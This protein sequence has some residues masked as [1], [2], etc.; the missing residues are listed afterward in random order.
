MVAVAHG[1][2][3][4]LRD[5]RLRV[6]QQQ[7]HYRAALVELFFHQLGFQPKPLAGT[8]HHRPARRGAAAHEQ[9]HP[10]QALTT[11]DGDF[12]RGTVF[13]HVEQRNDG[14]AWKVH[15]LHGA[16]GLVQNMA[17]WQIKHFKMG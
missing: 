15:I 13:H 7:V 9:R 11:D 17:E 2:L 1:C 14:S 10:H 16:A 8:L 6:T 12:A 5:E 4:H 3:R